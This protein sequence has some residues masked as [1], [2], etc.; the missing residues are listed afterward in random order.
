METTPLSHHFISDH[1]KMAQ[2]VLRKIKRVYEINETDWTPDER[3]TAQIT[4]QINR[5]FESADWKK[6]RDLQIGY[7]GMDNTIAPL[8]DQT[9]HT[10]MTR[11]MEAFSL[12][13]TVM[14]HPDII[15]HP[16]E[17]LDE[18]GYPKPKP[19]FQCLYDWPYARLDLTEAYVNH[20]SNIAQ[21]QFRDTGLNERST[22][23]LHGLVVRSALAIDQTLGHRT[24]ATIQPV[25]YN[26][27]QTPQ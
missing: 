8:L 23:V 19:R 16:R 6:E 4:E 25:T 9:A 20:L 15:N 12:R 18:D 11:Y 21:Q 7:S 1:E 24:C 27:Q 17:R 2:M 10:I 3:D 26:R 22:R 14:K 13:E 5:Y